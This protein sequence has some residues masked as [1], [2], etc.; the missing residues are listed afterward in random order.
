ML[1]SK[2]NGFFVYCLLFFCSF[3]RSFRVMRLYV[4]F[5]FIFFRRVMKKFGMPTVVRADAV[6]QNN[7]RLEHILMRIHAHVKRYVRQIMS[8]YSVEWCSYLVWCLTLCHAQILCGSFFVV[9]AFDGVTFCWFFC[10]CFAPN[11]HLILIFFFLYVFS[12]SFL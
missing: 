3:N 10:C 12:P 4:C 5:Y 6:N 11:Y 1:S 2:L 7:A 9:W 8:K